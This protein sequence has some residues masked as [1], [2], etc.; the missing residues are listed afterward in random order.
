ML[1]TYIIMQAVHDQ[2]VGLSASVCVCVSLC[3]CVCVCD[4]TRRQVDH[5]AR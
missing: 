1:S 3:V 2:Q 5:S 4:S